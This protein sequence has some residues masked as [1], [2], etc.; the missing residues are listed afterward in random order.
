MQISWPDFRDFSREHVP[1]IISALILVVAIAGTFA[2]SYFKKPDY[3]NLYD[4]GGNY[5]EVISKA[6]SLLNR[7]SKDFALLHI[8]A[9]AYLSQ[10]VVTNDRKPWVDKAISLLTKSISDVGD[11][12]ESER[13]IGYGYFLLKNYEKAQSY[14]EKAANLDGNNTLVWADLAQV[15]EVQGNFVKSNSLYDKALKIDSKNPLANIGYL[16]RLMREGKTELAESTAKTLLNTS[17]L[18]DRLA[19]ADLNQILGLLAA[20]K[21]EYALAENYFNEALRQNPP[22]PT[23]IAGLALAIIGDIP[24]HAMENMEKATERPQALAMQAL[25]IDPNYSYGYVVLVKVAK[26]RGNKEEAEKYRGELL[27][28]IPKDSSLSLTEKYALRKEFSTA[29]TFKVFNVKIT[30]VKNLDDSSSS[31]GIIKIEKK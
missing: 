12:A 4:T 29:S 1:V 10:G 25:N 14:Y 9:S 11:N 7:N 28:T 16:R 26:I 30:P 22:S 13:L 18:K 23:S 8:L 27:L 6:E 21:K 5:A 19:L 15:N 20:K 3:R 17:V 24:N 2:F 31:P